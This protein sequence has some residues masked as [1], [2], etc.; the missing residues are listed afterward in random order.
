[1]TQEHVKFPSIPRWENEVYYVT[2]K[3]DGT[4]AVITILEDGTFLTGSRNKWITPEDDNFGFSRWAHNNKE[5]LM[6]LGEGSHY[7]EWY[8]LGI[9]RGYGL[10]EKRFMLFNNHRWGKHNP[11]TPNC[12]EVASSFC[13]SSVINTQRWFAELKEKGSI[14]VPGFMKPEGLV[15]YCKLTQKCYKLIM[16]K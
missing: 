1:M 14:H 8:G 15:A 7:G 10:S 3:I 16:D 9:Q 4:N 2:E 12:V 11:E 13:T 5:E 6:K